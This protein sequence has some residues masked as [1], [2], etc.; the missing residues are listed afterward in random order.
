[1]R[2]KGGY[3]AKLSFKTTQTPYGLLHTMRITGGG[4]TL[5]DG[6]DFKLYAAR[7]A[8]EYL[9]WT[10]PVYTASNGSAF[11]IGRNVAGGLIAWKTVR[12]SGKFGRSS[13]RMRSVPGGYKGDF[14]TCWAR[15][16]NGVTYDFRKIAWNGGQD[17]FSV[18]SEKKDRGA[19]VGT[20]RFDY[21]PKG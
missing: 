7:P 16:I 1:M 17:G 2:V 12:I 4:T 10:G 5:T 20:H 19:V 9:S 15:N 18:I 6:T 14:V 8:S 11:R 3:T 13:Y 21:P